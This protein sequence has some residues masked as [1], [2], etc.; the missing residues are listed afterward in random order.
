MATT[1][2]EAFSDNKKKITKSSK[3]VAKKGIK[4]PN[5]LKNEKKLRRGKERED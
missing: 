3:A 5:L 1:C 2:I 4:N